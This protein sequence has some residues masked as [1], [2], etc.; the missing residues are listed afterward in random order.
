MNPH[1]LIVVLLACITSTSLAGE[2][3]ALAP[4]PQSPDRSSALSSLI[5]GERL[6]QPSLRVSVEPA[7]EGPAAAP[8]WR[9]LA[10]DE[11]VAVGNEQGLRCSG[12]VLRP[13]YVLTARHCLPATQIVAGGDVA[14]PLGRREVTRSITPPDGALDAALLELDRPVAVPLPLW[15]TQRDTAAPI[16]LLRTVGFGSTRRRLNA[17]YGRKRFIDL[18]MVGWGCDDRRARDTSCDPDLELFIPPFAGRDTC[19]GDSGGPLYERVGQYRRLVALTS[20]ATDGSR[21]SCGDGG[22][23]VRID[24]LAAWLESILPATPLSP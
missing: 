23:Y 3:S 20:R 12:V 4:P 24:R 9:E 11:V 15:R 10:F 6:T 18:P 17:A 14:T 8:S 22:I 2:P 1:A 19:E 7:G 13:R 5:G 21:L 16:G